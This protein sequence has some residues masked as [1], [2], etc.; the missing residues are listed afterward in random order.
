ML[1][2]AARHAA[3]LALAASVLLSAPAALA[4][5]RISG[6]VVDADTRKPVAHAEIELAN[7]GGGQGYF[8]TRTD[9]R[10]EFVLERVPAERYY[11]FTVAADG[12]TEWALEGWQFPEAQ[13][14]IRLV[15]PLARAGALAVSATRSDGRTAVAG[16]RVTVRGERGGSWWES[17]QRDPEPRFTDRAGA[18]RFDGL[19]AGLYTIEVQAAGLRTQEL[20]RV[21]VRP[22]PPTPVSL[23]LTRP[24]SLSGLVRLPDSSGV[25]GVTVI[26]RGPAEVTATTDADGGFTLADLAPGRY[27]VE[28]AH[29]GFEPGTARDAV[30][31]REGEARDLGTLR[32]N[33]RP[34]SFS[35][36]LEREVFVAAAEPGDREAQRQQFG[37]RAFRVGALDLTLYR[38]PEARLLDAARDFRALAASGADTAGL[39]RTDAFRFTLQAGAPFAWRE[40][41]LPLPRE[42]AP[43]AYLLVGR[44]GALER[45]QIFFVS[46]L[47]LVV[48]R[49]A[50]QVVAWAGALRTGVPVP[51]ARVYAVQSRTERSVGSGQ[52]WDAPLAAADGAGTATDADGLARLPSFGRGANLRVV[53]ISERHGVAVAEAPLGGEAARQGQLFLFT[54]RPLYRPGQTVHWKAFARRQAG[55]G[56]VMP[57]R[58]SVQLT[59]SG[60]E[61]ASLELPAA[62]LSESGSADGAVE[63]PADVPLGDWTL[64]ARG[65]GLSGSAVLGV[66]HYRKPEYQVEVT[67]DRAAIVGGDEL[68]FSVAA[69]YFF[70][71]P[72][73]GATV[74]W[75]LFESRLPR[76]RDPFEDGWEG[77]EGEGEG[78]GRMLESGET[79]TDVDGRVGLTFTPPRSTHDR[80]LSLEVEVVD[81]SQRQ[82]SARGSAIVGRGLFTLQVQPVA[83][84]TAAGRPLEVDVLTRDH[85]GQPVAAAVTLDLDQ[86]TWNPLERRYVRASRPLASL[87]VETAAGTGRARATIAPNLAR[88][89]HLTLRAR[90]DDARGNRITAESGVWV[91]DERAWS[92]AYRY[93]SLEVLADRA[94]YAPGDTA[95]LLVN[96]D[97][98]DAHLLVSVEG[99][100]LHELRVQHLFGQSG[101]VRV[102]LRGAY[103]A[104]AF[105]SV[106][107]RRGREVHSRVLELP[108]RAERHDLA[109]TLTP[110]RAEYRP[111][112]PGTITVET[113]DGAGRPVAAEVAVGV[114]D[115]AIYALRADGTPKSHDVFYG[116]QPN[117]VTTSVSFPTLYFAGA[118]KS[119][120]REPRRDFRDVAL[121]APKVITGADGRGRVELKWPDNLTTWRV[122]ARGATAATQVGEAIAR[123]RVSRD[124]VARLAVPRAF[125]AGDQA[126]LVTVV[127]N[128][129]AEPLT[130]VR[131]RMKVAGP[132]QLGGAAERT[133]SLPA[134][135]ES[136]SAWTVRTDA[137]SPK[138]GSDARVTLT[139]GAT[140]ANDADALELVVPVHPRAVPLSLR[141]SGVLAA[142]SVR[143][144][145]TLPADLVRSG[146]SLALTLSPGAGGAVRAA[147]DALLDFDYGCTEQTA[148]ALRASIGLLA[149]AQKAGTVVPGADAMR[150]KLAG[151]FQRLLALKRWD[152]AWGWWSQDDPD[153]FMTA[154][155]IEALAM[156]VQG[157][158]QQE[159]AQNALQEAQYGLQRAMSQLREPDGLAFAAMH[160][161]RVA[162]LPEARQRHADLLAQLDG[163]VASLAAQKDQLGPAASA[164]AAVAA[165]RLGRA[166]D[167]KAFLDQTMARVT[168]RGLDLALPADPGAEE[169]WFG[170]HDE[171]SAY[172]LMALARIDPRDPRGDGLVRGLLA[173]RRGRMWRSTRV[174]GPV[175][176]AL[177]EWLGAHPEQLRSAGPVTAR[178]NGA[179]A[180]AGDLADAFGGGVRV[181]ITGARLQ[182]GANTLELTAQGPGALLWAYEAE[183]RVPS[184][185][186]ATDVARLSVQRE[187]LRATRVADRR[188]RPRWLTAPFDARQPLAVGDAVLVRLTLTA[189]R[190]LSHLLIEDPRPAGFE[191]DAILPDG[192]ER[193]WST[194]GEVRDDRSVFF[195]GSLPQGASVIE[196]LLRPELEGAFTALPTRASGMYAPDLEVRGREDRLTVHP[197]PG[198][199]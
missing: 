145:V 189:P 100:E 75:T 116:R 121:W 179:P 50:T 176:V 126:S 22:G 14:D 91:Y 199:R 35:F 81:G 128:R 127:S 107:V 197:R 152:G 59:L 57:D 4:E 58:T 42:Q 3:P 198:P 77:S 157:G 25:A 48:K 45:R 150:D 178:W 175:A 90:A 64:S 54:E 129:T 38:I 41:L 122:T 146:S 154:L 36:V 131:E 97:V 159:A 182:P 88:S 49:S 98:K 137:E 135:G 73:V 24:A 155:A 184:P 101:L 23:A 172:A 151:R 18:V 32:V 106:H 143:H 180:A 191:V 5:S 1:R 183:A 94:E 153:P 55:E 31:V 16:A 95:R 193:P 93:P 52:S 160:L 186:P 140:A 19:P 6:Q 56:Y 164:C 124:L 80:R 72:V 109:I 149:A 62:S 76:D 118:D 13:R 87:T 115:E 78:Y 174:T 2:A 162:E 195:V 65:A 34:A 112:Q 68:R 53:A 177:A 37:V 117:T 110:D 141:G 136:R 47:S 99:R 15:V 39:V 188:G 84:M 8:R 156:C 71:A 147:A 67:P 82:V 46:D 70:G 12:F 92:Y 44:A 181:T 187:Y 139:F 43:G 169:R 142:P 60:P 170:E 134:R 111:Q 9:A 130:G 108:I 27:R 74:R 132:A 114:V 26:A 79:R 113:R 194:S 11:L 138:D 133:A 163:V 192:A 61:G 168:K 158:V 103:G 66:Q 89:G 123:T 144:T 29:E 165:S 96:T 28:V 120:G 7:A 85:A 196:Y 69:T 105:V 167:A 185:G 102:P 30:A 171:G 83:R 17:R 173:T 166:A 190:A 86:D 63:L 33:P 21:A 119:E 104:N 125:I 40:Q 51:G 10:G 161:A 148:N 20:R